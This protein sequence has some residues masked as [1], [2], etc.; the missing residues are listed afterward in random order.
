MLMVDMM[1]R[2]SRE[3]M[4]SRAIQFAVAIVTVLAV[5]LPTPARAQDADGTSPPP[6]P[7]EHHHTMPSSSTLTWSG[8]ANVIAGYNYQ[9]RKFADFWAWESQNWLMGMGERKLGAG[10]LTLNAMISLEP[11]TIG[12]L[13]YAHGL[14][15][16]ERVYA[17]DSAG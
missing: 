5:F 4:S 16:P 6:Q 1:V 14:G 8:D 11:W 10:T 2:D 12:R 7:P 15:G 17:F 9:D 3:P 13:V